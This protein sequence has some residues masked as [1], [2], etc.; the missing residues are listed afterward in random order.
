MANSVDPDETAR[1]EPS[2][3]DLHFLHR[4]LFRSVGLKEVCTVCSGSY[5][6]IRRVNLVRVRARAH[7]CVCVYARVFGWMGQWLGGC[8]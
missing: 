2:H 8:R 4:Y 6:R 1:Y 5:V 7:V 3:L